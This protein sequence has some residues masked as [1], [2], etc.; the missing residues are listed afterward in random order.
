MKRFLFNLALAAGCIMASPA[1]LAED[2]PVLY[3]TMLYSDGWDSN[4]YGVY[5]INANSSPVFRKRQPCHLL[6]V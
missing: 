5:A 1:I 4:E 6:R 3:G 2:V